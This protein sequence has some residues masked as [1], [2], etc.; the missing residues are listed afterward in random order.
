MPDVPTDMVGV[1]LPVCTVNRRPHFVGF[2]TEKRLRR[3]LR[4]GHDVGILVDL[5]GRTC[6]YIAAERRIISRQGDLPWGLS[7]ALRSSGSGEG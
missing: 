5:I 2:D 7:E 3:C 4:Y 1:V 6:A